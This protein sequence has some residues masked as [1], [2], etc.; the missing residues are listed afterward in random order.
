MRDSACV[1]QA[2]QSRQMPGVTQLKLTV[3]I[4]I[5]IHLY[6]PLLMEN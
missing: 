4:R 3:F 2:K 5:L 6:E 1:T